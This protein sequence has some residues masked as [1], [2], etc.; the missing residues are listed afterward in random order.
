MSGKMSDD[1]PRVGFNGAGA[2]SHVYIQ[3]PPQS[4]SISGARG[5]F[6][7]DG[8]KLLLAPVLNEVIQRNAMP[9][10]SFYMLR[11]STWYAF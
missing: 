5:L 11:L 10:C 4:C 6:Y 7:D 8:N 3:H 1:Q 2:L 9:I